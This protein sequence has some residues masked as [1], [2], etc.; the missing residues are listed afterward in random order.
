MPVYAQEFNSFTIILKINI[1]FHQYI[2]PLYLKKK[3]KEML[4]RIEI[5][6]VDLL[7]NRH[8]FNISEIIII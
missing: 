4:I 3:R 6:I 5:S 8:S 2:L 1:F 7:H